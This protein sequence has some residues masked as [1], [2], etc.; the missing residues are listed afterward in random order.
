MKRSRIRPASRAAAAALFA[1][2]AGC[3]GDGIS[4]PHALTGHWLAVDA[5]ETASGSRTEDRLELQPDGDYLW[6]TATFGPG[7]RASDGMLEWRRHGGQW[8]V[9][10]G[11][12]ALRTRNAAAWDAVSG[13]WTIMEFDGQWSPEYKAR[14]EGDRLIL[15]KLIPPNVRMLPRTYDFHRVSNFDDAPQPPRPGL[16]RAADLHMRAPP[17]PAT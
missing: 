14:Q 3:D 12:L 4:T 16:T 2:L 9:E 7:G 5:L 8:R 1:L 13:S 17:P 6:I 11:E 10:D 15:E